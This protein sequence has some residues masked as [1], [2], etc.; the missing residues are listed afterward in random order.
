MFLHTTKKYL[1]NEYYYDK[2]NSL[3]KNSVYSLS[4]S[5]IFSIEKVF[6]Y[7]TV[8]NLSV[9]ISSLSLLPCRDCPRQYRQQHRDCPQNTPKNTL[10]TKGGFYMSRKLRV[11]SAT[12]FY[13]VV[14][15]GVNHQI[16]FIEEED[17]LFFLKKQLSHLILVCM[18]ADLSHNL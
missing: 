9:M 2:I 14:L 3:S 16:L 5:G 12:G 1:R 7:G 10:H 11:R 17:Y 15:R 8:K 4:V 13:H 18:Q 6:L